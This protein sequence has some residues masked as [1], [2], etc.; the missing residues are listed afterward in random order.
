[1][2]DDFVTT[3][4]EDKNHTLWV[5]TQDKGICFFNRENN[6]FSPFTLLDNIT[7]SVNSNKIRKILPDDSGNMLIATQ[8]GLLVYNQT[9]KKINLYQHNADNKKSLSQNSVYSIFEDKNHSVWL[10][11]YYGGVN[12][13]NA[14]NDFFTVYENTT[15]NSISSNVVS[16]IAAEKSGN[17]IYRNRRRRLK[18][19]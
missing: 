17:L 8:D 14:Y 19:T 2:K 6:S 9:E 18:H 7:A 13:I 4:S 5:G 11:T 15:K 16:G 1:M 10:G 3:I 12:V